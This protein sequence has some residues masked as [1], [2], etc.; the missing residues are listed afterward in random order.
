MTKVSKKLIFVLSSLIF[1][2]LVTVSLYLVGQKQT[3]KISEANNNTK[4]QDGTQYPGPTEQEL[5]DAQNNKAKLT[6]EDNKPSS[7]GNTKRKVTPIITNA[8][9]TE[10]RAFIPSIVEE[11]GTCTATFTKGNNSFAKSSNGFANTS[12][13]NCVPII[14]KRSDFDSAGSWSVKVSYISST[15]QGDSNITN[16]EVR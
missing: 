2:V 11:T 6:N 14:L 15:F 4:A 8:N 9:S 5:I 13:T 10:I 1:I 12:N 7:Y 3:S 16:I